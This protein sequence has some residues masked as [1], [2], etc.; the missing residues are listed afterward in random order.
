MGPGTAPITGSSHR[1]V[2]T[3]STD[4]TRSAHGAM[5][6][7]P[8]A[9]RSSS[10]GRASCSRLED[11]H[12]P[13][14]GDQV[15]I[16]HAPSEQRVPL[17]EV[18]ADVQAGH[19]PGDPSPRLVHAQE[20]GHDVAQRHR[21]VVLA[22]QEHRRH[23]GAQNAGGDRV[24][25]GVVRVEELVRR[26]PPDHFGQFPAQV[27]RILDTG[28]E[29]LATVRRMDVGGVAGQQ[30]PSCAVGRGLTGRVGES[31]D[32]GRVVDAVVRPIDG[33]ERRTEIAQGGFGR[34]A[35]LSFGDQDADPPP[36]LGPAEGMDADRV[37]VD[38][39]FRRV[40]AQFGLRDQVAGR[41]IRSRELDAG[42]PADQAASAIA[43]DEIRRPQ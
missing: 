18:V 3:A 22:A 40:L 39:P 33:D 7:P 32:R 26:R 25:L 43:A 14:R 8:G 24:A 31:G 1:P 41:R 11:P 15:E 28:L 16:G 9:P 20:L 19:L 34:G 4:R 38:A 10:T 13:F 5:S 12:R 42:R 23:R 2:D 21:L 37:A 17:T 35:D 27:H 36:V 30:D 6:T 29:A